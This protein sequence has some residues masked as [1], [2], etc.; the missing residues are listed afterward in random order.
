MLEL[1][2]RHKLSSR[3]LVIKAA[4]D[5]ASQY[6]SFMNV[7]FAGNDTT[8]MRLLTTENFTVN[9]S[10]TEQLVLSPA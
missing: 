3:I 9:L 5:A 1:E 7:I 10:F 2:G 4:D 8:S 6:M